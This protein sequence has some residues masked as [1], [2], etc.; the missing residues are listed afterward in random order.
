VGTTIRL[1]PFLVFL[2]VVAAVATTIARRFRERQTMPPAPPDPGR[3]RRRIVRWG[4]GLIGIILAVASAFSL[5]QRAI[6]LIAPLAISGYVAGLLLGELMMPNAPSGTVRRGSLDRRSF[7][8]YVQ[9][10][11]IWAWRAAAGAAAIA[12]VAAGLT[13]GTDGRS[14]TLACA[15]GSVS[16]GGP[17]P[18]W[19]Y[20]GPALAALILGAVLVE[21]SIRRIV[22][23]RRPDSELLGVAVDEANREASMRRALAAGIAIALVPLSGVSLSAAIILGFICSPPGALAWTGPLAATL[24]ILWFA[25]GLGAIGSLS[26]LIRI[27]ETGGSA[28]PAGQ[29][30]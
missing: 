16:G 17:W 9:S 4:L 10:R 12:V 23:R 29:S 11:W 24:A 5:G 26:A 18:G 6:F 19:S 28:P 15:D 13:G 27:T 21:L 7:E 22:E 30:A 20:G 3:G 2:V 1:I 8:R 25:A 14:L